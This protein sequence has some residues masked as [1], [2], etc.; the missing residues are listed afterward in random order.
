MDGKGVHDCVC[1]KVQR[2]FKPEC[3]LG[4][5]RKKRRKKIRGMVGGGRVWIQFMFLFLRSVFAWPFYLFAITNT[6]SYIHIYIPLSLSILPTLFFSSSSSI[7]LHSSHHPSHIITND[8]TLC[9]P[10]WQLANFVT[11]LLLGR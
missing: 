7:R 10:R 2:M 5:K 3:G 11:S 4:W 1:E 8:I 6:L 9:F